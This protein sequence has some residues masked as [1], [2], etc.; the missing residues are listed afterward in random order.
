MPAYVIIQVN[1]TNPDKYEEYKK[2][3]PATVQQ[4]GGEFLVRGGDKEDLEGVNP[5]ERIVLLKFPSMDK[6][7][8]WYHSPEYQSAKAI[9]AGAG[10]GTFTAVEGIA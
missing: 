8:A 3:T 9:R 1:V 4:F 7:R 2:R 5:N 6:A 10:E